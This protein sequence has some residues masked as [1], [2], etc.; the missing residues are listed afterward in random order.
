[1]DKIDETLL[2]S[3]FFAYGGDS[4][5]GGGAR[6]YL[7]KADLAALGKLR[8]GDKQRVFKIRPEAGNPNCGIIEDGGTLIPYTIV[9]S[10]TAL[11]A[12]TKGAQTMAYGDP[13][14]FELGLFGDYTIRVDESIKGVERMYTILGDCMAGGNLIVDK[15]FVVATTAA[16]AGGAGC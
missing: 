9:P 6:L 14:H 12:G 5:T 1:M 15:G 10:L 11:S 13:M 8:N 3:L 7:N 4:E 2:D 16:A